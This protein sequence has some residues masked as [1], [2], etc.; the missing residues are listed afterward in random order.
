MGPDA[1]TIAQA[2]AAKKLAFSHAAAAQKQV[3]T[4]MRATREMEFS[5]DTS[6]R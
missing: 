6:E 5:S 1:T 4:A 2:V 3:E